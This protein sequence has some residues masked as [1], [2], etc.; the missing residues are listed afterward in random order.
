MVVDPPFSRPSKTHK[1]RMDGW[2]DGCMGQNAAQ[3][4]KDAAKQ[5]TSKKQLVKSR[6]THTQRCMMVGAFVVKGGYWF[7]QQLLSV[8]Y[9]PISCG[10]IRHYS[11]NSTTRQKHH[12]PS[13]YQTFG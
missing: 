8:R 2:M 9:S 11:E 4:L 10:N 5:E 1:A 6:I 12:V 3:F 13:T 7:R